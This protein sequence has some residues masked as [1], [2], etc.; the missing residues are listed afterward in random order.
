[1]KKIWQF[2]LAGIAVAI[3]GLFISELAG[4][5][6]NGMDYGSACVLGI[7]LYL[8]VVVV[9]CTGILFTKLGQNAN[10]RKDRE[11]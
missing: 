8:C 2:V 6:F 11:E 7:C 10:E 1:M 9:T 5:W 3:G 4:K